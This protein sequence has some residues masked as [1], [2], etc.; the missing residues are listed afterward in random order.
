MPITAEQQYYYNQTECGCMGRAIVVDNV[1]E[2]GQPLGTH[3]ITG[4]E[5]LGDDY[6]YCPQN[7]TY[8]ATGQFIVDFVTPELVNSIGSIFVK[9]ISDG[10]PLTANQ[11]QELNAKRSKTGL[12]VVSIVGIVLV[13]GLVRV[14]SK[15][16]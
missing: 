13:V 3:T 5:P 9:P 8:G 11:N 16:K 14:L 4:C 15:K 2:Q 7:V 12:L 10:T 6:N 1:N